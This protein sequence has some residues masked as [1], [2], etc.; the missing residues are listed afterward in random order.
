MGYIHD[1]LD[2]AGNLTFEQL[3]F[4][5]VDGM[6]LSMLPLLDC[7][8]AFPKRGK[9]SIFHS[10]ARHVRVH[11]L[12]PLG[13]IINAD[14]AKM[15]YRMSRTKRYSDL[16]IHN[17]SSIIDTTTETQA[18][19]ITVDINPHLSIVVFSGT[20]DTIVGWKE[21]F[22]MMYQNEVPCLRHSLEYLNKVGSSLESMYIVGHSKGGMESFYAYAFATKEIQDKVLKVYS[23]DGPGLSEYCVNKIDEKI[24][25]KMVHILP[26]G[27]IIG[28]MFTAVTKPT[29]IYSSYRGLHQHDPMSWEI[30]TGSNCFNVVGEFNIQSNLIKQKVDEIINSLDDEK[31]KEFVHYLFEIMSA[32]G[33]LTLTEITKRPHY[34]LREY[35][36][37]P[38]N[39]RKLITSLLLYLVND[40]IISRE[41]LLGA[42]GI[43]QNRN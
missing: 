27:G 5:E 13:L 28:R 40:K 32:G 18:T 20:D 3:P 37:L 14:I 21:D 43:N 39:V 36:K 2:Y 35:L 8:L 33:S 34:A 6:V 29:I 16:M 23:Y 30:V 38:S 15:I 42:I 1:Y 12:N 22:M 11:E 9:R 17:F 31:R 10:V 41:L 19:A 25:D 24:K 7:S 26:Q 4:N